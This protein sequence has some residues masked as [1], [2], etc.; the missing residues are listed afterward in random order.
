MGMEGFWGD[1]VV[2]SSDNSWTSYQ[3]VRVPI[4]DAVFLSANEVLA[5]GMEIPLAERPSRSTVGVILH[6]LNSGKNW[7][8]I[9]RSKSEEMF[10]SLTRVSDK[11]FYA[12]SD[13]GTFLKFSLK[14]SRVQ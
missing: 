11:E 13:D 4:L 1:L 10:V 5:S 3:L 9:Y 7:T 6:S 2:K 12:V 14:D 8:P